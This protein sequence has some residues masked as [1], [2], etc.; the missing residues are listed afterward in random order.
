MLISSW[1]K[2]FRNHLQ[3]RPRRIVRRKTTKP[4]PRQ[5][6]DLEVR[7]LLAAPTLVAVRPNVGEFLVENEVRETA[8]N[9]LT[10]QF[11]P[12]QI[13]DDATVNGNV[14]VTRA[15]HDGTFGDG[16]EVPVT[17][18]FV[19]VGDQPEEV[20]V[21]FAEN[22]PD[23]H[24][25]ITI[26]PGLQNVG[27]EAF[28]NGNPDSFDFSLDLGARIIAVDPQPVTR[29]GNGD[30]EQARNQI[31]LYFNEDDLDPTA[32]EDVRLYQLIA[33]ND[34]VSNLDDTL[35]FPTTATYDSAADTVTLE[36]AGDIDTLAG[37]G[38]Y[39]LRVGNRL[40][41]DV[42]PPQAPTPFVPG[43]EAGATNATGAD[44]GSLAGASASLTIDGEINILT[45]SDQNPFPFDFPGA[46]DEPGHRLVEAQTHIN[47]GPDANPSIT[48]IAYNFDPVYGDHPNNTLGLDPI[49][50]ITEAQ[51]QRTREIFE[52]YGT[53]LGIDFVETDTLGFTIVTGDIRVLD[54]TATPGPGGTLG[55][56][57]GGL[58]IMDGGDTWNDEPGGDWFQTAMHEIGHLLGLGHAAELVQVT[59][60]SANSANGFAPYSRPGVGAE[61]DFPGD[62][63]IAHGLHLHRTDSIDV[64]RYNFNVPATGVFTVELM[65]ERLANS[66]LLDAKLELYRVDGGVDVLV[67]QNDDYFSEDSFIELMLEPGDYALAVSSTDL[68]EGGSSQGQYTLRVDFKE[69]VTAA[70]ALFDAD[71]DAEG[72]QNNTLFDGDSDGHAGGVYNFWFNAASVADTLFVDKSAAAGGDGSIATPFNEIDV[73]LATAVPG[74]IVRIVGNDQGDDGDVSND[75]PYLIGRD[76]NNNVLEDGASLDVPQGVTVMIDAGA[77]F[78]LR[79][80]RIGVGSSSTLIDR[81]VGALQIL[82]K[83]EQQVIF[84]SLLDELV[85]TDTTPTPTTAAPGNWGGITF[86]NDVDESQGRFSYRGEGIFINHVGQASIR[87][88]GGN[89]VVDSVVQPVS[90][91]NLIDAQPT[92]TYNE[93]TLSAD[94]ALAANPDSFEQFTFHSPEFQDGA[95]LFTSDYQRV[96]PDISFN[97]LTE[98]STNGIFVKVTTLAGSDIEKLTTSARFDDT[99]IVHVIAQ[100][101]ALQGTPGGP[102]LDQ[103]APDISL[104]VATTVGGGSATWAAAGDYT[105]SVVFYDENGFES[106]NSAELPPATVTDA[107]G[108]IVQVTGLPP[109]P[110]EYVGRRVY[111]SQPGGG[112]PFVLVAELDRSA[113]SFDDTGADLGRELNAVNARLRARIDASLTIDPGTIVKLEGSRIEA[114]YGTQLLAEGLPGEEIIFT[115]RRDDSYGAGGTFDTND[116]DSS[117]SEQAPAAG[118][119]G[120]LYIGHLGSVSLDHV[121]VTY[122]GGVTP[123]E[124]DFAAFNALEIHQAEARI[125][126]SVFQ[127]NANGTTGTT[128][129][130]DRFG[131]YENESGTIFVRGSQPIILDS[132]FEGNAG[133]VV[134]INTNAVNSRLLVDRGRSTGAA[135]QQTNYLDN[136]GPLI[137]DNAYENNDIN[138]MVV[139]GEVVT[140]QGVWDD[141]DIVHVLQDEIFI[142]DFHVSGGIRL[143]SSATESLVVKLAGA[144]AGITSGGNAQDIRDRIGGMLHIIGQPGSPVIMTSLD[145]DSAGAGF[146]LTGFPQFD[147]NNDGSSVG[148]SGSWRGLEIEALA[149]DRNVGVHVENELADGATPD[150]NAT[151]SQAEVVGRLAQGEFSSDENLRL[152]FEIHGTIDSFDDQDTYSFQGFA[153]EQVWL[154]IDDSTWGLDTVVELLDSNGD[155]LATSD[156]DDASVPA[157]GTTIANTLDY[158]Q[159]VSRDLYTLNALDAGMRVVLPGSTGARQ[160]YFVRVSS[161]DNTKGVYELQIRMQELDE[162]AG[163]AIQYADIRYATNGI[164]LPSAPAH[165]PLTAEFVEIEGT[166]SDVGAL[167][168]SDRAV[169]SIAGNLNSE[170]DVDAYAFTVRHFPT[171]DNPNETPVSVVFDIDFADGLTR[172]DSTIAVY[173]ANNALVLIGRDSNVGED[174]QADVMGDATDLLSRGSYGQRDG[175][176]GP[177]EIA[178]GDYTVRVFSNNQVPTEIAQYLDAGGTNLVRLEPVDSVTRVAEERFGVGDTS[179]TGSAPI[180]DLFSVDGGGN[181][182]DQ[183]VVPFSLADVSLFISS[184]NGLTGGGETSVFQVDPFTGSV[185]N[186]VGEFDR[187]IDD[188]AMRADGQLYAY[189]L[190]DAAGLVSPATTGNYIEID[191]GT[192]TFTN[193]GDDG[194]TLNLDNT[195]ANGVPQPGDG[196]VVVDPSAVI[197]YTALVHAGLGDNAGFA[198][199]TRQRGPGGVPANTVPGFDYTTNILYQFNIDTGLTVGGTRTGDARANQ[200]AGSTQRE[201]GQVNTVGGGT[202]VGLAT[203]GNTLFG[204]DNNGVLYQINQGNAGSAVLGAVSTYAVGSDSYV[205]VNGVFTGLTT[206]P[207]SVEDGEYANMLFALTSGGDLFAINLQGE[208]Q[209]V[210]VDGADSVSTGVNN[211]HG[212]AFS[213]L[214]RNLWNLTGINGTVPGHGVVEDNDSSRVNENGGTSLHFGNTIDGAAQGNQNDRATGLVNDY[215]FPGGAH[216]SVISNEFDLSGYSAE[217]K[218]TLYFNYQLGTDG[219]DATAMQDAFR[220]FVG[221]ESGNWN[222]VVTNNGFESPTQADEY[223]LGPFGSTSTAPQLQ[224]FQDVNEAFDNAGWRQARVDLSNYAGLGSLRLRFDF[225]TAGRMDIVGFNRTETEL[226]AV[227]G[228]QIQDGDT[229]SIDGVAFEFEMGPSLNFPSGDSLN[230]ATFEVGTGGAPV[231]FTFVTAGAGGTSILAESGDSAATIAARVKAAIEAQF[232]AGTAF[233][234]GN[235]VNVPTGILGAVDAPISAAGS[236]GVASVQDVTINVEMTADEVAVQVQRAIAEQFADWV[237]DDDVAGRAALTANQLAFQDQLLATVDVHGPSIRLISHTVTNAGVLTARED[238]P[239]DEFSNI[240]NRG[241]NNANGGVFI[242]DII[243][244]FAER[245]EQVTGAAP[246]AGF[247]ANPDID[248]GNSPLDNLDTHTGHYDLEI[249]RA[250]EN[251]LYDGTNNLLFPATDT[252]GRFD[253]SVALELPDFN[254]IADN[255]TVTISDGNREVTFEFIDNTDGTTTGTP[256]NFFIQYS[257]VSRQAIVSGNS[258]SSLAAAFREAVNSSAVQGVIEIAATLSDGVASISSNGTSTVNLTGNAIVTVGATGAVNVL[259]SDSYGDDNHFR[260][261]GQIIIESSIFRDASEFGILAQLNETPR[262]TGDLATPGGPRNLI[263]RNP[264]GLV[265]GIVVVNNLLHDNASGGID[266]S[267]EFGAAP[268]GV[269]PA[270]RIVNNTIAAPENQTGVGVNITGGVSATVMNNI[271]A[272]YGTWIASTSPTVIGS[273]LYQENSAGGGSGL[274][275]TF[276]IQIANSDP[277]F[278]DAAND[279][280]YLA[281]G[282]RAIDSALASLLDNPDLVRVKTPLQ[283]GLSPTL[284]PEDDLFGQVRSDDASAPNTSG[285][286]A[287]VFIDRGAIDRVDFF[288]PIG[289]IVD[290]LD[291]SP[292]DLDTD[293]DEVFV[294]DIDLARRLT[295][296]LIDIGVG[297]D[298]AINPAAGRRNVHSD[299]FELY[300]R[301]VTEPSGRRLLVENVDYIFQYN[302]FS[303]EVTFLSVTSYKVDRT[304]EIWVK[305]TPANPADAADFDGVRDLAGNYIAANRNDGS[306]QFYITLSDGVN[307]APINTAPATQTIF[308]DETLV[309]A[310]GNSISVYDDD[311]ALGTNE[312][313]V[314]L[315]P[316]HGT[317]TTTPIAG[318]NVST[319]GPAVTAANQITVSPAAAMFGETITIGDTIFTFVDATAVATPLSTD[320]PLDPTDTASIVAGRLALIL[321]DP[322]NFGTNAALHLNETVTLLTRTAADPSSAVMT[323]GGASIETSDGVTSIGQHVS[324]GGDVL[325]FVDAAA[326][327]VVADHEVV[328]NAT[329]TDAD[330]AA[331]L[332]AKINAL[333]GAGSAPVVGNRIVLGGLNV[334]DGLVTISGITQL[335]NQALVNA[336]F[337]PDPNYYGPASLTVVT[338]DNGE[339]TFNDKINA[340]DVDVISITVLPVNDLPTLDPIADQAI[341]EDT[342]T[343][344]VNMS[345]ISAGPLG[346]DPPNEAETIRV[347]AVSS[348]PSIIPD[349]VVNYT[350]F[351]SLGS[352]EFA[353]VP[354]AFG[355]VTITVT[356]ED[357]GLDNVFED[358]PNTAG[359]DESADNLSFQQTFTI[360]VNPVND[361]PAF[362]PIADTSIDEDTGPG[363]VAL[364]GINPGPSGESENVRFSA[365][366]SNTSIIDTVTF[367]YTNPDTTGTLN[368][369]LVPDA[370]GGPVTITVTLEDAGLD[371]IFDDDPNTAGID[372]SADNLTTVDTFDV[373]VNPVNDLPTIDPIPDET[374]PEDGGQ[375]VVILSGVTNGAAN[376]NEPVIITATSSDTSIIP[377]PVVLYGHPSPTGTLIYEPV[378][379]AFGGP[380]TIT[381]NVIDGGLDGLLIDNPATP[382][383]DESADNGITVETFEVTI[384]EVNDDPVIDAIPTQFI[385]EDAGPGSVALTG[386]NN[387]A[388]NEDDD[389]LITAVS[390]DTS[391]VED[392]TIVYTSGDTTGTLNYNLVQDAYGTATITV[393]VTDAGVDNVLGTADDGIITTTFD[394]EVAPVND[395]PLLDPIANQTI[396]EDTGPGMVPLTGIDNG[397]ANEMED[398]RI[399]AVSSNTGIIANPVITYTSLNPTGELSYDLVQDAFGGPVTIT[400]TVE[401]AGVDGIFDDDPGTSL[402]DESLDNLTVQQTFEVVVNPV[403]DAPTLDPIADQMVDE[404]GGLQNV[405]LTGISNG[406]ANETE[407]LIV[408]TTSSDPSIVPDPSVAYTFDDTTGVLSYAPVADQHGTVTIT[409][410][411]TDA[412]LDGILGNTDDGIT[413]QT[414]DITVNPVNDPPTIDPLPNVNVLEDSTP[415]AVNLT[416]ITSGAANEMQDLMVTAVSSDPSIV[417]NPVVTYSS[418]DTTGTLTY[419]LIGDAFGGP[420]T[421]TVFVTDA[422]LDGVLNTAD[423]GVTT[424]SFEVTVD[425]INDPPT[426]DPIGDV[427]VDEDAPAT[428]VALTGITNGPPN[429]NEAVRVSAVSSDTSLIPHP[430]VAYTSPDSNGVLTFQPVADNFGGPVTI[431]VTV[432]DAGL[433]NL[434][435]TADDLSITETFDITVNAVND[436]P[437]LNPIPDSVVTE[438]DA[439]QVISLE[440]ITA[441]PANETEGLQVT[442]TIDDGSI[443]IVPNGATADGQV[444]TVNGVDFT[445]VTT[446]TGNTTDIAI[447]L[448][449]TTIDVAAATANALNAHFG[450]GTATASVNTVST[451]LPTSTPSP[452]LQIQPY[453]SVIG[454]PIVSY[455]SPNTVGT[456]TYLPTGNAY[457]AITVTVTVT[458]AG[459]D[460]IAGNADDGSFSQVARIVVLPDND[461]PTLDPLEDLYLNVS[462]PLQVVNLTGISNGPS[463][464]LEDIRFTVT[465]TVT[466]LIPTPTLSYTGGPTG[467]LSFTPVPNVVGASIIT[468]IIEDAGV[469]G[470]FDDP[471]TPEDETADNLTVV[472]TFRVST[473]PQVLSPLGVTED[474]TPEITFTVIP[475]V[476]AYEVRLENLTEDFFVFGDGNL[477]STSSPS[478]Q[479]TDPLPLGDYRVEVR[480]IDVQGVTGPWSLPE[481]F[482]IAPPPVIETP[483]GTELPDSTPTFSWV[484]VLGAETYT[485][486][487]V[488]TISNQVVFTQTDIV[489]TQL[490]VNTPLG[491]GTYEYSVTAVNTPAATSSTGTVTS[492]VTGTLTVTTAPEILTPAVAIYDRT[493]TI[494]WIEPAGTVFSELEIFNVTTG[495]V[496]FVQTGITG[497]SYTLSPAQTLSDA[498]YRAVVRSFGDTQRQIASEDSSFHV[499]QVGSPPVLLGPADAPFRTVDPRPELTFRGS[500][501]GESYQVWLSSRSQNKALF[502]PSGIMS[503]GYR[504]PEDLPVG[505]YTYWVR[506]TT[507]NETSPW[508]AAYNFEVVTPPVINDT[509]SETFDPQPTFTWAPIAGATSYNAWLNRVDVQPA[510]VVEIVPVN[511]TSYQ[512]SSALPFG[513]YKLWIRGV[514][515]STNPNLPD[516]I[517]NFS[518][519]F[520][521]EVGGRPVVTS[522]AVTSDTTPTFTWDPVGEATSYEIFVS[523]AADPGV[524]LFRQAGISGTSYT[525]PSTLPEG[526]YRFWVRAFGVNNQRTAWSL[527]STS[528]VRIDTLMPPTLTEIGTTDDRTPTFSWSPVTGA[529]SYR[530]FVAPVNAIGS[531]TIDITTTLTSFTPANNVSP[532]TY[533]VWVRA[534][535]SAGKLSAWSTPIDVIVT[536]AGGIQTQPGVDPQ[537][538]FTSMLSAEMVDAPVTDVA[539]SQ[540]PA[541]VADSTAQRQ[542]A[543]LASQPIAATDADVAVEE[544][545]ARSE[546]APAMDAAFD[547]LMEDWDAAIWAEETGASQPSAEVAV[548]SPAD[549]KS[550]DVRTGWAA[551]LA[552]LAPAILKRRR[553]KNDSRK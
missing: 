382:N 304:Y 279:N 8:P 530:L 240:N 553:K 516:V 363:T 450:A 273:N 282:S 186:A 524:A 150:G 215:N 386:I 528:F 226:V 498:E 137:R 454:T 53:Y 485:L 146:D 30:L 476:T 135:D 140:T 325:T 371:N 129:P 351:E 440:G 430:T 97:T 435:D 531:P 124:S 54:P 344:Q 478:L 105:Y 50:A 272:G 78:K 535:T 481:E 350:F 328:I 399:S 138:G 147:T 153:G 416:G 161:K 526:D 18:G 77:I 414:F 545:A 102:V 172:A 345:G 445:Y 182:G 63:D 543:A 93:I 162:F 393:T 539:V 122:G 353:P 184:D 132:Q 155:V 496:E 544:R 46:E 32:A 475:D 134:T 141:T 92:I 525:V 248:N 267:G 474:N 139:R 255:S 447:N 203:A 342:A 107:N 320:V 262:G 148:T 396:D 497:A 446:A 365:I 48:T 64:D 504:P 460:G 71:L 228:D 189:T 111:R 72:L 26:T 168:N 418:P 117:S 217:D 477:A 154:D 464:E 473:A 315:V 73:A 177:V 56:A 392:P 86:R 205:P 501:T 472:R 7:S 409:V 13:I 494:T 209:P 166:D 451:L 293:E 164:V 191:T 2:S 421:I 42:W 295:I 136:Q 9:E 521:F 3:S 448:T 423:D 261:Q 243:I 318:V 377:D 522:D 413:S 11:N 87:Y 319:A 19:G 65:A 367:N 364:T 70:T 360:T 462:D 384:T 259:T 507:G 499:F 123:L 41:N 35:T 510:E 336:T 57:G 491:L 442:A 253:Q 301:D 157:G 357:A 201:V 213:T 317:V 376:E 210:F 49:N 406:P 47:A 250:G 372:E 245:G 505:L 45:S 417:T 514:A 324:V 174:Q 160:N 254:D 527:N 412:G 59:V 131:L 55:I 457:G 422:G 546:S 263:E 381:V 167:M 388:A 370:F 269:V 126:N 60:N 508:S 362:D 288:P 300:V 294:S 94:S 428:G 220:V 257:A 542:T 224:S 115:S 335:V 58:A 490:T 551:S 461:A 356:V 518:V 389:I 427:V 520:E 258:F 502:T 31:V 529:A 242:D 470:I 523:D 91:I 465:S 179:T 437:T 207:Q 16:N 358:D 44:L 482:T 436:N 314:T 480:A 127:T 178:P 411:A 284:A 227:A 236:I 188:I 21:R 394:I 1:L 332:A 369:T 469:D 6:E 24:Y 337:T 20:V 109:A 271:I 509:N 69:S 33:T 420:V 274:T 483:S 390:S 306:T 313:T 238:L 391:I 40:T 285:Q 515:E 198:V 489:D 383:V 310:G 341:D 34:T 234:S 237:P 452:A 316:A 4:A 89:A 552:A 484:G 366:S 540:L 101:L 424:T 385:D 143:E 309:F 434:F 120:G 84:T 296:R 159:F 456:L 233:A 305:N 17:I 512:P 492:S 156:N 163:T 121:L 133:P 119:W 402:I 340:R 331:A 534:I 252:N 149:H 278:V 192:G 487:I 116:D 466:G 200:G 373:I 398:V 51:K 519:G 378:A 346:N 249:R 74:Q 297:I 193:D 432:E 444:L 52:F 266:V 459:L 264:D 190:D 79:A 68:D 28:N 82:G 407:Q 431:T 90:P 537:F 241:V 361:P 62:H 405:A 292:V 326:V 27:G 130:A 114:E 299:Q 14:T 118:N 441:G 99:D 197:S 291:G 395:A 223:D 401:D 302:A 29:N 429:E 158:S 232:G 183:H 536:E 500:L 195:D 145:D 185:E 85:G 347:T 338:E 275:G 268:Q 286:G 218:P 88:G 23:D 106:P 216:G 493:P 495:Q 327:D 359:V 39:R 352:L 211:A 112:G 380:V 277:L 43:T 379:D 298:D 98:N 547:G 453:S 81:S 330:V 354:D 144:S 334:E 171:Q 173:D 281:A 343:L 333:F 256:G 231:T 5:V 549:T 408:T 400:V 221:D 152:G 443:V 142:P 251:A 36:F 235:R 180:V 67:A 488:D 202:I 222:L 219:T 479:I 125:R 303:K 287:N 541:V 410:T 66:S 103:T 307:D 61:P 438:D 511:G 260:D 280:Y 247:S 533:R 244:G 419:G 104:A 349:P 214:E 289:R 83:P 467:T 196:N 212:L 290:P 176:I 37:A 10:L 175:F 387:G 471:N 433:D 170:N 506:A 425:Q 517:T 128:A 265:P 374:H 323:L 22:L 239:G 270:V 283:I 151:I 375:K 468:V 513:K 321:N 463:N 181:L 397:P 230:G 538:L 548:E 165:S 368:Y 403:N 339:F 229:F 503:E 108:D 80:S 187:N 95:P 355:V 204:L 550:A 194:I 206:A 458:D 486:S 113:P 455:T 96:G 75:L 208:A 12:G 38:S 322:K 246:T 199:G 308:E 449:D 404:D 100:N 348:D 25:R 311:V 532:D 15:G 329:D 169:I 276:D 439:S 312:L 76:L 110:E 415:P 426:I 225:S